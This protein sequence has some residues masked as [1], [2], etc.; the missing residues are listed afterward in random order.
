MPKSLPMP[1][2]RGVF[3][4]PAQLGRRY[5][6]GGRADSLRTADNKILRGPRPAC[7]LG[8]DPAQPQFVVTR[9]GLGYLFNT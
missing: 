8:F 7:R 2:G 4:A 3:G 9:R 6:A 5:C 1:T